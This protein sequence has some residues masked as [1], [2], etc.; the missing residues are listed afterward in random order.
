MSI[1]N[2]ISNFLSP[3]AGGAQTTPPASE[4]RTANVMVTSAPLPNPIAVFNGTTEPLTGDLGIESAVGGVRSP[5][6][7]SGGTV[8]DSQR[9]EE[10]ANIE[11]LDGLIED[12]VKFS[13]N[14]MAVSNTVVNNG[15]AFLDPLTNSSLTSKPELRIFMIMSLSTCT[16]FNQETTLG[17]INSTYFNAAGQ[18]RTQGEVNVMASQNTLIMFHMIGCPTDGG[19]FQAEQGIISAGFRGSPLVYPYSMTFSNWTGS[20]NHRCILL[21]S[22]NPTNKALRQNAL[23]YN[24]AEMARIGRA[25]ADNKKG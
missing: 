4:V 25:I 5:V 6:L 20:W 15:V 24:L 8:L 18:P 19:T 10:V 23:A 17:T 3:S 21:P 14:N 2:A 16:V 9:G 7:I 12:C 1:R 22:K 13:I 11:M